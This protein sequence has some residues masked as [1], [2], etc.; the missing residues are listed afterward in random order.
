[1]T[2]E[3][4]KKCNEIIHG[5]SLAAAGVGAGAAAIPV[6]GSFL[7]ALDE[8]AITPI[9]IVMIVD[10]GKIFETPVSKELAASLLTAMLAAKTGRKIAGTLA[11]LI[12]VAGAII[13]GG[14]AASI[15]EAIGWAAVKYFDEGKIA[16]EA[17]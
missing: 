11:G 13:N 3:Q 15:T 7:Q 6:V 2:S 5:A 1:M 12:P 17:K 14:T 10:I 4:K 16:I 8:S 9:Q